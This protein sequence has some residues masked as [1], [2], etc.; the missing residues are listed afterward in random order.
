VP[1]LLA[2]DFDGVISDSAPESF[3]VGLLTYR[4]L[5]SDT[6]SVREL[7]R[8][9]LDRAPLLSAVASDPLYRS[10]VELMPL[11]N[12]AED[13]GVVLRALDAGEPLRE[14]KDYDRWRATI[15]PLWLESFHGRFYEIRAALSTSDPQG[16]RR[17]MSPYPDVVDLLRRRSTDTI[18]TIATAKDRRSVE[19]LLEDY[20]IV[21]LFPA[22]CVFDKEVGVHKDQHIAALR[23]ASGVPFERMVFIDDK[24]NHLEVVAKL[25]VRCGLAAW[26][27]NGTREA[28]LARRAGHAVFEL[29][30]VESM[31]FR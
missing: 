28:E 15:D 17:L 25:G 7:A 16:W 27:Y 4:D 3:V 6:G 2:L 14:Q 23:D 30:N 20:G 26:G 1:Q 8:F 11:G 21:D 5:V 9:S 29:S 12:R 18:L 10:F 19:I 24:L 22:S 31:L 13:F